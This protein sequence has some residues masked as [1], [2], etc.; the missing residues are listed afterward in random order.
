MTLDFVK[1]LIFTFD[2]QIS[3]QGT[4]RTIE[5]Q[6]NIKIIGEEVTEDEELEDSM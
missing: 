6:D 5:R 4:G 1:S 2:S 3:R